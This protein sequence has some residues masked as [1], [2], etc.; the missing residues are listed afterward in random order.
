MKNGEIVEQGSHKDL[1]SMHG[2]YYQLI[3]KQLGDHPDLSI[4]RDST[5]DVIE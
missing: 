5:N 4:S 3:Q 2:Y 1:R